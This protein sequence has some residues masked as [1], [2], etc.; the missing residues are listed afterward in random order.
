MSVPVG[1]TSFR[2]FVAN[3]VL[4]AAKKE[5]IGP[6]TLGYVATMADKHAI[7]NRA[8]MEHP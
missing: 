1:L 3:I 2:N 4:V 5:V 8:I 7:W 6:Y